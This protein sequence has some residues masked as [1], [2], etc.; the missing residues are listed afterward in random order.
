ME[1]QLSMQSVIMQLQ[2]YWADKGC[3]I[4]QPYYTQVGAGTM[5]PAT[6]LR[7]LGPEPWNV[8]Y[9]EPSVRPDDGRYGENPNRLQ[10]HYQFQVIL[11]PDPGNP[12]ELYLQSLV[13]LGINPE[14]HDL[15]F[16]EDNWAS[17][18]LGAWGL[19]WEVWLDGQEIT[20]FTY[21]QQS[22]GQVLE[23][24]SVELTYG[25]ERILMAL[26]KVNSFQK[27]RWNDSFSYG[28]LNL[29]GEQEHSAYYFEIADVD[30]LWIMFDAFESEAIASLDAGLVLPAQDYILKCS[31]TFNILD[32]RGA[33]GVTERAG[34]FARMRDLSRR[35]AEAY[36]LKRE[37]QGFP[38][39]EGQ[40]N[41][42]EQ[43]ADTQLS[44]TAG[45]AE[46]DTFLLE[47]GTEELPVADLE[48]ARMQLGEVVARFLQEQR[49]VHTGIR[50]FATP[51]RLVAQ[52]DGLAT[53]QTDEVSV[54]KGPPADRAY[55]AEGNVTK[56]ALGFARGQG[57]EASELEIIE[58]NG[59]RYV[60]AQKRSE[61]RPAIEVLYEE[62]PAI[63]ASIRFDKAMRW[64]Q[65]QVAFSRPLR[66]LLAMYGEV[67][68]PFRYADLVA[69]RR[70][71]LLRFG[72]PE[73]IEVKNP[74]MYFEQTEQAGIIL[75]VEARRSEIQSQITKLAEEVSGSIPDDPDLLVEV[76]NLVESPTALRGAFEQKYLTLPRQVLISV[77]KKHQRYFPVM[78]DGELL[79]YFIAVRNGD[80]RHLPIVTDGN[81][82]VIQARFADA[83]YFIDRDRRHTLES[84]LPKLDRL[85]FQ[86][87]LG[88]MLDK[89]RRIEALTAELAT[90]YPISAEE[91]EVALRAA[92]LCK[93]DL[94][95]GMVVEMTSL[96]GVMGR[97]Y[98]QRSGES[99][100]VAT[101]IYEHYLPRSAGDSLPHTQAG[102]MVGFA[103]RLDTLA[104]LFSAGL[105]PTG[106]R[107]PYA[108]RRSAIGLIH[109]LS[110]HGLDVDLRA[111]LQRAAA[112]LP[113][114]AS[115]EVLAEC[116]AF[117]IAREQAGLL[118][119]G[120]PHDVVTAVLAEQGQNPAGAARAV[121]DLAQVVQETA[122]EE[123]LQAFARC[124][125]I[126]RTQEKIFAVNPVNLQQEAE[127]SLFTALQEA[128]SARRAAG[129]VPDFIQA[130]RPM[131]PFI[132]TFFDDVLV[133]DED[134]I[135]KNNRLGLL[136]RITALSAGVMDLSDLEGF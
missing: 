77:M 46:T 113:I 129:S 82:Q 132:R 94:A 37:E 47:I 96:Q 63:V 111:D 41:A 123:F 10:Q 103:D 134:E 58:V 61:G 68:I 50:I 130:F 62:L 85:T 79:P 66:W 106:T 34:M 101:A 8:A 30:R 133:M 29:Q 93:A 135:V 20:Q 33:V 109:L 17:P 38:W 122:W 48:S 114:E 49:L 73:S 16:V 40:A 25:L 67:V 105:Q 12:Q 71:C 92:R 51:R 9:V 126:T 19:G 1:K 72:N 44:Y 86:T 108:L 23:P 119:E 98:A 4:W 52:V 95:S 18:A 28:D 31:H 56:A 78:G 125:R 128:E 107:D 83:A 27:I 124:V 99:E 117:I 91:R 97:D 14:E 89:S 69:G 75:D 22:G 7:V 116:L 57:V 70:T 59:G 74:Q 55:D 110:G 39:L 36:L 76:A 100:A 131:I 24:V 60:S 90:A 2:A 26:Q 118:A 42:D 35:V 102:L 54:V 45:Q 13:A 6:S 104:G 3:V 120:Y 32:T 81:E 15:R 127:R 87:E 115:E 53:M 5:N 21:F 136:Q 80:D 64:N 65:S 121:Q 112:Q 84:F 43:P 11:K 88:S